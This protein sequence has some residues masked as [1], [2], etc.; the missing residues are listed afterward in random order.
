MLSMPQVKMSIS[1]VKH[2]VCHVYSVIMVFPKQISSQM[3][4]ILHNI[5][6][7]VVKSHLKGTP[8]L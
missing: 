2:L 3:T 1:A 7:L 8:A 5:T 6:Q 4:M